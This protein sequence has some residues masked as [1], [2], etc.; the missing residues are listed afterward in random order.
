MPQCL[1]SSCPLGRYLCYPSPSHLPDRPPFLLQAV[2]FRTRM[3]GLLPGAHAVAHKWLEWAPRA[4]EDTFPMLLLPAGAMTPQFE[5][6]CA[7]HST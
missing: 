6:V 4:P 1:H 3:L 2:H 5:D 7:S